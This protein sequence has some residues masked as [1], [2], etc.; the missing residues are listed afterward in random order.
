MAEETLVV[1]NRNYLMALQLVMGAIFGVGV[2]TSV[3]TK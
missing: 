2:R 1:D 3:M